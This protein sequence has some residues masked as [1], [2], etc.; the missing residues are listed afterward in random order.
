MEDGTSFSLHNDLLA[1]YGLRTGAEIDEEK[2]RNGWMRMRQGMR[3]MLPFVIWGFVREPVKNW[4]T[5]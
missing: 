1:K 2:L 3:I 5:I 4:R